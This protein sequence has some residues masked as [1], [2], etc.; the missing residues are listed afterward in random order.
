MRMTTQ[1]LTAIYWTVA[2]CL[3]GFTARVA[4]ASH[5]S[6]QRAVAAQESVSI[7]MKDLDAS[8]LRSSATFPDSSAHE[9]TSRPPTILYLIRTDCGVCA[10]Q[11]EMIA[12]ELAR[13]PRSQ[14]LTLSVQSHEETGGYWVGS[15]LDGLEPS[16]VDVNE[17]RSLAMRY[18]PTLLTLDSAGRVNSA[19]VGA[20]SRSRLRKMLNQVNGRENSGED[21]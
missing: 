3:A 14:I 16:R 1:N 9:S 6:H 7:G 15:P 18:V 4:Y 8:R 13:K 11:R 5:D 12:D 10:D 19:W 17:L 2:L 21:H 20:I